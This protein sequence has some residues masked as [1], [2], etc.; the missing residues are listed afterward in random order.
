MNFFHIHIGL[1]TA[2]TGFAVML[3]M[4][5]YQFVDRP[6]FVPALAAVFAL[7]D[8]WDNT[9]TFGKVRLVS[10]AIGGGLAIVYYL[11]R[12]Y[13]HNASWLEIFVIPILVILGIII[14][15]KIN[16]NVGIVG[17]MAAFLMIALT[18]PLDATITYVI[19][20]VLDVFIGVVV[21]LIINCFFMPKEIEKIEEGM[22]K[23]EKKTVE[24]VHHIEGKDKEKH[25]HD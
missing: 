11:V 14:H 23:V 4:I 18:I 13:T 22:I 7:R 12:E 3:I 25:N 2:K 15:D 24:V 1:R 17:G 21:A 19:L 5:A 10:N 8:T 16:Y 6:A 20:R 9:M